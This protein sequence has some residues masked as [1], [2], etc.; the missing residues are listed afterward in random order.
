M[1]KRVVQR[2]PGTG[3][4]AATF[5]NRMGGIPLYMDPMLKIPDPS[6]RVPAWRLI[7]I[8]GLSLLALLLLAV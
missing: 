1:W 8:M 3:R 2:L 5:W 4:Y 7:L 6:R